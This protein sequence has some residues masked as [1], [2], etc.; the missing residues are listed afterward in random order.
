MYTPTGFSSSARMQ[1]APQTFHS[2]T[3]NGSST[4][5]LMQIPMVLNS[6][7]ATPTPYDTQQIFPVYL[8]ESETQ[9][10]NQVAASSPEPES[11]IQVVAS[12]Q[13]PPRS[14]WEPRRLTA[15]IQPLAKD[16]KARGGK[17]WSVVENEAILA[18]FQREGKYVKMKFNPASVWKELETEVFHGS[19]KEGAIKAQWLRLKEQFSKAEKRINK[20]GEGER[21][22]NQWAGMQRMYNVIHVF[23]ILLRLNSL[24][25][26]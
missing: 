8:D 5:S 1:S 6:M 16:G 18:Y 12:I 9:H 13:V 7:P 19:R 22:E 2:E 26:T 25:T 24:D 23:N 10:P 11:Q 20:T 17:T 4:P 3:P 21:D 15:A 14:V